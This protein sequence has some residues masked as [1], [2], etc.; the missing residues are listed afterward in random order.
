MWISGVFSFFFGILQAF[1]L[2]KTLLFVTG[3]SP[4]KAI[5]MFSAKFALYAAALAV[6]ILRFSAFLPGA[7][8]G[9]AL[10]FPVMVMGSFAYRTFFG[11][12]N[13]S[14]D[15]DHEDRNHP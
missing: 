6:L 14:G 3:G 13:I 5:V 7:A 11:K 4:E 15:D 2:K 1:L 9:Y 8:V 10:G 12:Q